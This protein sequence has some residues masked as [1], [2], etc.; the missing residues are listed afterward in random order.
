MI[1]W[2]H[3]F[4]DEDMGYAQAIEVEGFWRKKLSPVLL[5]AFQAQRDH[6]A[7]H[8]ELSFQIAPRDSIPLPGGHEDIL[9]TTSLQVLGRAAAMTDGRVADGRLSLSP[10]ELEDQAKVH[11]NAHGLLRLCAPTLEPVASAGDALIVSYAAPVHPKNLVVVAIEDVA[12]ARRFDLSEASP[13]LAILTAQAVNPYEIRSP[14]AVTRG[15]IQPKKI[16]GVLYGA[17]QLGPMSS[18]NEVEGI[19]GDAILHSILKEVHGLYQVLGRSAEPFALDGQYLIVQSPS[20]ESDRLVKS[21]GL[22]VLAI[23][24]EGGHYFK[25]LRVTDA[26]TVILESLDLSGREPSLLLGRQPGNRAAIVEVTP[27]VGVLFELPGP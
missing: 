7:M 13:E 5:Q 6:A 27:V 16:V 15:A 20:R 18:N 4:R 24:E 23:D 11:L 21:N 2:P 26:T 8:G 14:I 19:N 3:H 12:R 17:G 9:R 22:L 1:N 25:R 10:H